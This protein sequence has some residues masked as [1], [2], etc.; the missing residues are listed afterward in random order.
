MKLTNNGLM[1]TSFIAGPQ[2][3]NPITSLPPMYDRQGTGNRDR[4]GFKD[5]VAVIFP[6][7]A[8]FSQ[9][10]LASLSRPNTSKFLSRACNL[11]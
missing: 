8:D 7:S 6:L 3:A 2:V 4:E 11:Y 5:K 9:L 10:Y 1:N